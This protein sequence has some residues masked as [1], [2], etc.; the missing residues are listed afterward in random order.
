[1]SKISDYFT[2]DAIAC[3]IKCGSWKE[4]IREAGR[5]LVKT[6]VAEENFIDKMIEYV[7]QFGPY[8]VI[9]PG[10]ALAHARPED[11]V[12][13]TGISLITLETPVNFGNEDNDPVSIVVALACRERGTHLECLGDIVRIIDSMDN[14]DTILSAK[15]ASEIY[16]ILCK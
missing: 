8:I 16:K 6:G 3:N 1:M 12:I 4:A 2:E 9:L 11:G 10:F 15:H 13:K 7:E 5:L 14:R